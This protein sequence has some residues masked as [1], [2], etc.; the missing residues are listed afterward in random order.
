LHELQ[1]DNGSGIRLIF[2]PRGDRSGPTHPG[3]G[4]LC[5][6]FSGPQDTASPGPLLRD[7]G[8]GGHFPYIFCPSLF[9]QSLIKFRQPTIP[10]PGGVTMKINPKKSGA[11]GAMRYLYR[12]LFI[13]PLPFPWTV[14]FAL[15]YSFAPTIPIFFIFAF[16]S[17]MYHGTVHW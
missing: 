15:H 5:L 17:I 11:C 9:G 1:E 7:G 2:E 8:K 10:P 14:P 16:D 13:G 3:S 4:V 12:S 6:N